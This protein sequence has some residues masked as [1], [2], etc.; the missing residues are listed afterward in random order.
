MLIGV[1][2]GFDLL[3]FADEMAATVEIDAPERLTA[4]AMYGFWPNDKM[5]FRFLLTRADRAGELKRARRSP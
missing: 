2:A 4:I 3:R 1:L 5:G